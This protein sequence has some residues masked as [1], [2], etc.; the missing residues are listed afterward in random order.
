MEK[1]ATPGQEADI[2]NNVLKFAEFYRKCRECQNLYVVVGSHRVGKSVT[3][4]L[5][6]GKVIS[7]VDTKNQGKV[8]IEEESHNSEYDK[9]YWQSLGK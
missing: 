1:K 5:L 3:I 2:R 7:Q 9:I 8:M 4:D 6:A